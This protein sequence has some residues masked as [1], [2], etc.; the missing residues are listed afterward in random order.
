MKREDLAACLYNSAAMLLLADAEP[1]NHVW[2][3]EKLA[4][5]RKAAR[6]ANAG[7][8]GLLR[9]AAQALEAGVEIED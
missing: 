4:E 7:Q 2:G 3:K 6:A 9:K 8:A 5:W 1:P